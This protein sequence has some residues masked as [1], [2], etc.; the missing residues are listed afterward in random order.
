MPT[1]PI[2]ARL[3]ASLIYAVRLDLGEGSGNRMAQMRCQ[4]I[5]AARLWR[6]EGCENEAHITLLRSER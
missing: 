5:L 6:P 3:G 1:D 4:L 2:R